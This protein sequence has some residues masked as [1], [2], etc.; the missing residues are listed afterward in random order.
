MR[1]DFSCESILRT[2]E[3]SEGGRGSLLSAFQSLRQEIVMER[4]ME[5]ENGPLETKYIYKILLKEK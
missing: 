3:Q 2:E 5:E 1:S 4:R